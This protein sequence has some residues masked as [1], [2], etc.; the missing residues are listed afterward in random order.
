MN[1]IIFTLVLFFFSIA[2]SMAQVSGKIK[3]INGEPL[4]FT[5]VVLIQAQDSTFV[6]GVVSDL[7]GHFRIDNIPHGNYFL[8]LSSIGYLKKYTTAFTINEA[9]SVQTFD[10]VELDIEATYL[11]G[12][13]IQAQ[14]L[15]VEQKPE[16]MVVN[17]ENSIM[18]RGSTALQ[19]I[20]RA[21]GVILDQRNNT[22]TLNGQ[23]GTLIMING[24]PIRMSS[25]EITNLL[26][27]MSADNVQKI[28]LLTNPSAKYDADGGAGIINLVLKKNDTQGTNGSVSASLGYGYGAKE[29]V[30]LNLNHR[31]GN[32]NYFGTY[33]FSNDNTYYSWHAIGTSN[34]PVFGGE[35]AFDFQN[36]TE[37]KNNSHNL[38]LG[39]EK[40]L[41]NTFFVGTTLLYN[42]SVSK[43]DIQNMGKNWFTN[44]PYIN[45]QI[46]INGQNTW[47]NLNGTLYAEKNL[48]DQ[49]KLKFDAD[50]LYYKNNYPTFVQNAYYDE[51]GNPIIPPFEVFAKQNRGESSTDINIGIAKLD[52]EKDINNQLKLETGVKG[53]YSVTNNFAIIEESQ[54]GDWTN[55]PRNSTSSEID[56]TIGAA[57]ASLSYALDTNTQINLGIRY[58]R[59]AR[60][61]SDPELD[62]DNAEFFPSLFINRKLTPVTSLQFVYNKRISRP[63]Y[64]DLAANL[65]YNSPTSVFAGNPLLKPTITDNFRLS[66]LIK[67][68]NV[69]L[70][71]T[72]E[73]NPIVRFQ[74]SS[75]DE[76]DLTVIAPQNMKYQK[77]FALQ[78]NIPLQL[79]T[80][81]SVNFGGSIGFREFQ[82]EHTKEQ[83]VKDYFA[84]NTYGTSTFSLPFDITAEVSGFY[85]GDHYYG[86]M[87]V[88]GFGQLNI[89]L[90]KDL[91]N[92]KG[93]FQFSITDVLQSMMYQNQMGTLTE[94]AFNTQFVVKFKPESG[95]NRIYRLTFTKS[96]GSTKVKGK[97]E[98]QN[99]SSEEK[100]RVNKG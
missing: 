76:S 48:K 13:E 33:A 2:V 69:S 47:D 51:Q 26:K 4:P 54:T 55:E 16:G 99:E 85:N 25:E 8:S 92:D 49:S 97:K 36:Q 3:D 28:E 24:R 98:R 18:S 45:T 37:Q 15:M 81:W 82:M 39:M 80:W 75:L 73:S 44:S 61:F 66:Y 86:S 41:S 34:N 57:Y 42:H 71:Y 64:N 1:R 53:S 32:T 95:N 56:E 5:N 89:G 91:N 60:D 58:E 20:E 84:Y 79:F 40:E 77:S 67:D 46:K 68:V 21:P 35:N 70:V 88:K 65:T 22:L 11:E 27:G 30:S 63:S 19:L 6:K 17:V 87:K 74:N 50:Y 7:D 12:V 14:K 96:F 38:Q 72:Y 31:K 94:E 78:T 90:K 43:S 100:S 23:N 83:I 59:W 93:S 52:W 62:Q 9:H 29:M 10:E